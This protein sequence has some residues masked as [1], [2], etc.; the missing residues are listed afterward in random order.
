MKNGTPVYVY[1]I[2]NDGEVLER[3]GIVS[4]QTDKSLTVT[5]YGGQK[6]V[7]NRK[8]GVIT[9]DAMWSK[10]PQKNVYIELMLDILTER[11]ATYQ[12]RI[13]TTTIRINNIRQCAG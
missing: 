6:M 12:E 10:V 3:V 9:K 8:S 1:T 11:R 4:K 2:T 7:L 13:R 5:M